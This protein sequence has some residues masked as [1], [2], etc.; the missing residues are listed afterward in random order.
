MQALPRLRGKSIKTGGRYY[1]STRYN[2]GLP[3]SCF[4]Y[5]SV[6]GFIVR[7]ETLMSNTEIVQIG[8]AVLLIVSGW[9]LYPHLKELIK[10]LKD[11]N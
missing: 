8:L 5:R 11:E 3:V 7:K 10:E 6:Q 4:G 1:D 9:I 2:N